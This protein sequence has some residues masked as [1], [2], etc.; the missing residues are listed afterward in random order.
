MEK[1]TRR[2]FLFGSLGVLGTGI[3]GTW[4]FRRS[5][6]KHIAFSKDFDTNFINYAPSNQ[7]DYCVLT[8]PLEEGPFFF[9]SPERKNI[10]ED[11]EGQPLGLKFQVI[12][13]PDCIP[14]SDAIVE[15]WHCDANGNYSGYPEE[16]S[17]DIWK[18]TL[19]LMKNRDPENDAL[20]V[21]PVKDTRFLRG[22]QTT[23]ADGWTE[24]ETIFPGWYEGRVPHVHVK[25]I[26]D[27]DTQFTTQF[28]PEEKLCD[29]IF[30]TRAPYSDHGKCPIEHKNDMVLAS[31]GNANGL[32][33]HINPDSINNQLLVASAKI[34]INKA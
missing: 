18:S 31:G 29:E 19:F 15:I 32:L 17:K 27:E 22:R 10:R 13:H 16:I 14:I 2:K 5:I 26:L 11:R 24:F 9:P 34:G 4:I 3:L 6:I 25:V 1:Q 23:N 20:H 12:S 33:L 28:F 7:E 21:D 8:S 30:T